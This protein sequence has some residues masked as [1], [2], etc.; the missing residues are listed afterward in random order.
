MRSP[1]TGVSPD[2]LDHDQERSR[3]AHR[4]HHLQRETLTAIV[5]T[6]VAA[7]PREDD[8]TGSTPPRAATSAP[9]SRPSST[10]LTHLPDEQLAG[11]LQLIDAAGLVGFKDQTQ[12]GREAI[13]ANVAGMSPEAAGAIA[14]LN[15]LSVLFAYCAAGAGGPQSAVGR[16]GVSGPGP[17][18]AVGRPQ[19]AGGHHPIR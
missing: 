8:P 17:G 5:D 14:A 3:R 13:I 15:Q 11:L 6:F 16:H 19:D 7:V 18:P 12:A 1:S 4:I 2:P 9:T 10:S